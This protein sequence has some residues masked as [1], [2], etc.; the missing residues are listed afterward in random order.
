MRLDIRYRMVFAYDGVVRESHQEIRVRP[1]DHPGQ[2]LLAYRLTPSPAV[3]VLSFVDYWGTSVDHLGLVQ[4]HDRFEIVAEAAVDTRRVPPADTAPLA[5]VSGEHFEQEHLE[6]LAPSDH[7][8][9]TPELA[10]VAQDAVAAAGDVVGAVKAVVAATRSLLVYEKAS[11]RIGIPLEEMVEG[12]RGVCQDFT[13]LAIGLLRAVGI[14]ARYVSG[15]LFASDES[16]ATDAAADPVFVQTHAWV[17]AAVPG[18]GWFAVDPTNLREVGERHVV[19][20]HGRDYADVAP[21][22]GIYVGDATPV[23]DANVEIRHME[24]MDT[25]S[26]RRAVRRTMQWQ[27]VVPPPPTRGA[28]QQQQ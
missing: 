14:P 23:V 12:G 10:S 13:H 6:Y 8:V 26:T 4:A 24:P 1:A 28:S 15:Y 21:V 22:R 2:R 27:V 9:W 19:I 20:G 16:G 25:P 18:Q 3:R 17:E 7:V 11:T 5:S